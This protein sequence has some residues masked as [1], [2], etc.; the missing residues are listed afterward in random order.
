MW[1][2]YSVKHTITKT[3]HQILWV[4]ITWLPKVK[5]IIL[6]LVSILEYQSILINPYDNVS[7]HNSDSI[8]WM[9]PWPSQLDYSHII[10]TTKMN[11]IKNMIKLWVQ[12]RKQLVSR[13]LTNSFTFPQ[14]PKTNYWDSKEKLWN[15]KI[16]QLLF[17]KSK[18][19]L[20]IQSKK[21]DLQPCNQLR[22]STHRLPTF[23]V[24]KQSSNLQ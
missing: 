5:M 14:D 4:P 21:V 17:I 8:W 12:L 7:M 13:D 22:T 23:K 18:G 10:T 2:L 19:K 6:V 15:L 24:L 9:A 1:I 3:S 11:S 16:K 20:I